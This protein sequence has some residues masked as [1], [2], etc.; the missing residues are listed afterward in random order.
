[1]ESS[2]NTTTRESMRIRQP[3]IGWL[4]TCSM[5]KSN[6]LEFLNNDNDDDYT[7]KSSCSMNFFAFPTRLWWSSPAPDSRTRPSVRFR[8]PLPV[9][10]PANLCHS[11]FFFRFEPLSGSSRIKN[12]L[13]FSAEIDFFPFHHPFSL[14]NRRRDN[15]RKSLLTS[16]TVKWKWLNT[17]LHRQTELVRASKWT[18]ETC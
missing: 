3:T 5:F 14:F 2:A 15:A 4:G 1:M 9:V 7:Y 18:W 17:R 8:C 10:A 12:T 11:S 13:L 6:K 16:K